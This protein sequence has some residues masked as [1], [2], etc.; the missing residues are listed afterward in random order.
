[1]KWINKN[2][3]KFKVVISCISNKLSETS[4]LR[5]LETQ[6]LR[7]VAMAKLIQVWS[8]ELFPLISK[9]FTK[10]VVLLLFWQYVVSILYN[11]VLLSTY[12]WHTSQNIVLYLYGAFSIIYLLS[13]VAGYLGDLKCTRFRLLKC[14]TYFT[15]SA[16]ALLLLTCCIPVIIAAQT[17]RHFNQVEAWL[18]FSSMVVVLVM[19]T[20]GYIM[21]SANFIQ[22]SADQLRDAPT[23]CCS[24]FLY[25]MLW[26]INLNKTAA[27]GWHISRRNETEIYLLSTVK[28]VPI[29]SYTLLIGLGLTLTLAIIVALVA[30]RK[31]KWFVTDKIR[32]NPYKLVA[33]VVLF[34]LKHKSPIR[35]SAFTFCENELPS[36]IDFSKRRYGGPYSTEQVEDVKVLLNILKILF[37][38]G[39][40]YFLE[41]GASLAST[42]QYLKI[43]NLELYLRTPLLSPS[44]ASPIF[45]VF[46]LPFY[47]FFIK[48][49]LERCAPVFILNFFK[50]MG[51]SIFTLLVFFIV[52][53]LY[54]GLAYDFESNHNSNFK[55][56]AT[57][58]SST[59]LNWKIIHIPLGYLVIVQTILI[60][61]SHMLLHISVW[62]FICAQSPQN[63]KGLLFGLLFAIRTLFRFLAV[64]LLVPF[65]FH[66]KSTV[67]SC[68]GSYSLLNIF[69]G[70]ATLI[71]FGVCAKKYKYRK[72]DDICPYYQFAEDYYS[73]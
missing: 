70:I 15:V 36:R 56:C 19:Y 6:L 57:T 43:S 27:I 23:R 46:T 1:V 66:W 34:A 40:A 10:P 25:V 45:V 28:L 32:G 62:E 7:T 13:P 33:S 63:M 44:I 53:F 11:W 3:L 37:S 29:K 64:L 4:V 71:L 60:A 54:D 38:L 42:H 26:T 30:Q 68:R 41:F 2:Q 24:L 48:P 58:N 69:V 21:F 17:T 59:T 50:R 51:L 67:M 47:V 73:Q 18:F 72:R 5:T 61:I 12:S 39:P 65:A 22:F 31:K 8:K 49:L 9:T 55:N 35:R 52:L 16:Y 14:G 20:I